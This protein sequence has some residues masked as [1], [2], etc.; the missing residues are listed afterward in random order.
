MSNKGY[1]PERAAAVYALEDEIIG[2]Q[3][4]AEKALV[5]ITDVIDDYFDAFS[6]GT[7]SDVGAMRS[8]FKRTAILQNIVFDL[9]YKVKE[10]ADGLLAIMDTR[11]ANEKK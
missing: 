5:L 11:N 7:P 2:I 3:L 8:E 4:D 9:V 1:G 6:P 10:Q